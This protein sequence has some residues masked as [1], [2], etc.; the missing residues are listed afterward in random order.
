MD[1]GVP[2]PAP[3]DVLVGLIEGVVLV[4]PDWVTV[5]VDVKLAAGV[6]VLLLVPMGVL[7][8]LT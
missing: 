2:P 3:V 7:V 5:A 8:G 4:V 6:K 1:Q